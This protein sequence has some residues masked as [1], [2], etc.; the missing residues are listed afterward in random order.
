MGILLHFTLLVSLMWI[1]V[2]GIRMFRLTVIDIFNK[3][4]GKW[5][6][7]Y[8]YLIFAYGI[9]AIVLGATILIAALTT[10]ITNAYSGDET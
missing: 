10:G 4:S 7:F 3:K 2:E 6:E 8:F 1:A 9:P 5:W